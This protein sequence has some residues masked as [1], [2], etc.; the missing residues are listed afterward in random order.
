M[1]TLTRVKGITTV[2]IGNITI[3]TSLIN[4]HRFNNLRKKTRLKPIDVIRAIKKSDK[5]K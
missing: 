5:N 1:A 3:R 2:V 4:R